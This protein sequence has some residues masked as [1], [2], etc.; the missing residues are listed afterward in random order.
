[1]Q[2]KNYNNKNSSFRRSAN[3]PAISPRVNGQITFNRPLQTLL[4]L[5]LN[6]KV[7][8]FQDYKNE[9]LWFLTVLKKGDGFDI[10]RSGHSLVI[11]NLYVNDKLRKLIQDKDKN[12]KLKV[13]EN[14]IE[15][16]RMSLYKIIIP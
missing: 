4:N 2:L 12:I 8:F 13:R 15:Y 10:K 5:Q 6:D 7:E 16:D 14:P 1:M 11:Q 9:K 3:Y